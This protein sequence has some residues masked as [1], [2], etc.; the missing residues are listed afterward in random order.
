[1]SNEW[2]EWMKQTFRQRWWIK[3][4]LR[5]GKS[6][7]SRLI[8]AKGIMNFIIEPMTSIFYFKMSFWLEFVLE[9]ARM[10]QFLCTYCTIGIPQNFEIHFRKTS[11]ILENQN[12]GRI[13]FRWQTEICQQ[14]ELKSNK[15][16]I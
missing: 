12:F 10:Q 14:I 13:D 3:T 2:N 5:N 11:N 7:A 6:V 9:E 1:M 4:L 16:E 8:L 15:V